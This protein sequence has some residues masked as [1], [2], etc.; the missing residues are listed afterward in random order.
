M[1]AAGNVG[2]VPRSYRCTIG[3]LIGHLRAIGQLDNTVVILTADNGTSQ[4]GG[5]YGVMNA[6]PSARRNATND[7]RTRGEKIGRPEPKKT[8]MQFR[9]NWTTSVGQKAAAIFPGVGTGWKHAAP[10]VQAG[11]PRWR[12][13]SAHDRSLSAGHKGCRRYPESVPSHYRYHTD[14][15]RDAQCAAPVTLPWLRPDANF[16]DKPCLYPGRWGLPDQKPI[17]YFE[18]MGNRG[19]WCDG[20]KAVTRHE[21]GDDYS[22]EEWELYHLDQDFSESDNLAASEPNRLQEMIERWWV[23]AGRHGVL[24]LDD[25]AGGRQPPVH[26]DS[27]TYHFIPPM[28]HIPRKQSPALEGATGH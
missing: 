21:N 1:P 26:R 13:A 18:M 14:D 5:P 9:T 8:L 24:P 19:L 6:G 2:G 17:Q 27:L 20:W 3:R 23:E 11:Y 7:G 4:N 22:N 28:A 25:R 16:R 15:T 10:M 12:R